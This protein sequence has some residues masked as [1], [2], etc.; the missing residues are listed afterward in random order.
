MEQTELENEKLKSDFA[1]RLET[2]EGPL[3]LLLH[4]IE[5][6]KVDIYDIPISLITDQYLEYLSQMDRRDADIMSEFLVMATTLLDIK[7]KMLLPKETDEEGNEEDPRAEL[8]QRLLEYKL[9]KYMSLE[10]KDKSVAASCMM[11]KKETVPEEIAEYKPPVDLDEYLGDLTL[12][13]IKEIFDDCMARSEERVN[14]QV[15]EYGHIQR[16]EVKITERIDHI[17]AGVKRG[18][19]ISFKGLLE[20]QRSRINII[21]TFLAVLE[22]MKAGEITAEQTGTGEDITLKMAE[23]ASEGTEISGLADYE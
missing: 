14:T 16:E 20:G 3:D 22:L 10:L 23:G 18:G 7:A 12:V 19:R 4:L 5:K 8:V 17:R 13:K 21:V 9:F 6:N 11:Y 2:F 15:L 1:A